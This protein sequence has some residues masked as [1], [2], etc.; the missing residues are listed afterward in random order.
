MLTAYKTDMC[1]LL[2]VWLFVKLHQCKCYPLKEHLSN[3]WNKDNSKMDDC[4]N[5][6]KTNSVFV[7]ILCVT[8]EPYNV[9]C[10]K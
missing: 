10:I 9:F 3:K 8:S 5:K 7:F 6:Q 2:Y 4:K 1:N